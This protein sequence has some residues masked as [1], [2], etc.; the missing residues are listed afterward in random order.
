[1]GML[2]QALLLAGLLAGTVCA[3]AEAGG[4]TGADWASWHADDDVSNTASLQRGARNF[5]AYCVGCHSLKY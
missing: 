4:G 3:A 1:M 2:K 5:M